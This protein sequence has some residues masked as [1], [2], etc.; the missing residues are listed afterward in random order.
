MVVTVNKA[1][2]AWF[3]LGRI[4]HKSTLT[5]AALAALC[6]I[7]ALETISK[8]Q[9][10]GTVAVSI[11][12]AFLFT[13]FSHIS[14]VTLTYVWSN[15]CS[16]HT[17]LVA[18]GFTF[19]TDSIFQVAYF[20]GTVITGFCVSAVLTLIITVM[21]SIHTLVLWGTGSVCPG[22]GT[23]GLFGPQVNRSV[24][25]ALFD[26]IFQTGS[27]PCGIISASLHTYPLANIPSKGTPATPWSLD[28]LGTYLVL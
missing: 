9:I 7:H 18:V 17:L 11:T 20:T 21:V 23:L 6:M 28:T 24:S 19:S 8:T 2:D 12:F 16:I 1:R 22:G 15:T 14:K 27:N 4:S 5:Q 13:L 25:F 26:V 10:I 3:P